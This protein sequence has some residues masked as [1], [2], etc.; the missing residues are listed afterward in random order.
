MKRVKEEGHEKNEKFIFFKQEE[1][2][3]RKR[4]GMTRKGGF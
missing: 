2:L 1:E 3:S 4:M